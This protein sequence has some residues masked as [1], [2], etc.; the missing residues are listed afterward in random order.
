MGVAPERQN[1][2][3]K[4]GEGCYLPTLEPII[5]S[6]PMSKPELGDKLEKESQ[7]QFYSKYSLHPQELDLFH[8]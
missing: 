5:S 4:G 8:I 6:S 2:G 7:R 1:R 3:N